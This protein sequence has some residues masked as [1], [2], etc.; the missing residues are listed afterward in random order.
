MCALVEVRP[1]ARAKSDIHRRLLRASRRSRAGAAST[2]KPGF[3]ELICNGGLEC[4]ATGRSAASYGDLLPQ[5][6]R[7]SEHDDPLSQ[8]HHDRGRTAS[9]RV[10][11]SRS[12]Q[13]G[14]TSRPR[15]CP[16][17]TAGC[18]LKGYARQGRSRKE[19]FTVFMHRSPRTVHGFTSICRAGPFTGSIAREITQ[20]CNLENP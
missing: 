16:R 4:A 7:R 3:R 5:Q 10:L 8:K 12:C 19:C 6:L 11:R 18:S 15:K 2:P 9:D 1:T 17:G 14:H 13:S 20:G